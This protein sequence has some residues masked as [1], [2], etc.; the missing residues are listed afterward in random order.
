M[1]PEERKK[2]ELIMKSRKDVE[3]AQRIKMAEKKRIEH[4]SQMNRKVKQ[5]EQNKTEK[6]NKIKYGATII[7]FEPPKEQEKQRGG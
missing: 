2:F 7:K 6:A 1:S 4:L 5:A 3:E